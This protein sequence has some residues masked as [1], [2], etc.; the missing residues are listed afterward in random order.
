M[1]LRI[2]ITQSYKHVFTELLYNI[3]FT[4]VNMTF[5]FLF[6]FKLSDILQQAEGRA[7]VLSLWKHR[8]D[9]ANISFENFLTLSTN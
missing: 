6:V 8:S 1:L 4:K 5:D 2:F 9:D 3:T 7:L